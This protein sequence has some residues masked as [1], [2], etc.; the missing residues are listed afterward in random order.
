MSTAGLIT[1]ETTL[2]IKR[3]MSEHTRRGKE[4]RESLKIFLFPL[5]KE[6]FGAIRHEHA[7]RRRVRRDRRYGL[8]PRVLCCSGWLMQAIGACRTLEQMIDR[9][10]HERLIDVSL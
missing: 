1:D 4:G 3:L 5:M 6:P 10:G 8:I 2:L 7:P 9:R